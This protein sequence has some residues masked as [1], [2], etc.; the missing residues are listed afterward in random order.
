MRDPYERLMDILDAIDR[1]ERYAARGRDALEIDELVQVWM[2]HHIQIIGEAA[3]RLGRDFHEAYPEVPWAQIVAMRNIL[4]HEYFGVDLD[5]V[6]QVIER[7]LPILTVSKDPRVYIGI[8][9]GKLCLIEVALPLEAI[10]ATSSREGH[11]LR[12]FLHATP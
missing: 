5:E 9:A 12:P 2:V 1:I 11:P 6:W 8:F 3:A 4:V 7:D 10:N